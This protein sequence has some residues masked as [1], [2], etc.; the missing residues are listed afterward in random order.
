VI[1]VATGG[2]FDPLHIG[3]I[4]LFKSAKKLGDKLIVMLNSDKQLLL[5]KGT[6]FMCENER[7][8]IVESIRYV[9]QVIID[10]SSDCTCVE[11]L[12]LLKPDILAKGGDRCSDADMPPEEL[13]VCKELGIKI[14]YGVG[15]GKIQSSSQLTKKR[16]I[17]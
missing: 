13:K 6:V 5:K 2:G 8:A 17:E 3:H 1:V 4:E 10:P 7:K 12:K 16:R 9:D 11:A 14:V 15:G